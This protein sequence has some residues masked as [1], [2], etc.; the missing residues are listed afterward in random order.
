[1]KTRYEQ[2]GW[3][4]TVKYDP[5]PFGD[6]HWDVAKGA[7][8]LAGTSDTKQQAMSDASRMVHDFVKTAGEP[9]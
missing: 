4:L 6:R 8:I 1:M 5:D 9:A 2:N 7:I 3:Q